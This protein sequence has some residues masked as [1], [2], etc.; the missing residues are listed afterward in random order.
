MN[1]IIP[2]A[3]YYYA[4]AVLIFY[5]CQNGVVANQKEHF[6]SI[7]RYVDRKCNSLVTGQPW[8]FEAKAV[9]RTTHLAEFD[10]FEIEMID[11]NE[12]VHFICLVTHSC[13]VFPS[14]TQCAC[15][16]TNV[17]NY[18]V[19]F[20]IVVNID[21]STPHLLNTL[22][23][24][25]ISTTHNS[26]TS[27]NS[28][29]PYVGCTSNGEDSEGGVG[30]VPAKKGDGTF[31]ITTTNIRYNSTCAILESMHSFWAFTATAVVDAADVNSFGDVPVTIAA[32]GKPLCA[33]DLWCNIIRIDPSNMYLLFSPTLTLPCKCS[34]TIDRK[35][36]FCKF[37]QCYERTFY[38]F[39]FNVELLSLEEHSEHNIVIQVTNNETDKSFN[40]DVGTLKKITPP[41]NVTCTVNGALVILGLEGFYAP[42]VDS[43]GDA[44]IRCCVANLLAP[45]KPYRASC[46][47]ICNR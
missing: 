28:I 31:T 24:V 25:R 33:F 13:E 26:S 42:V 2:K 36:R 45:N 29:T 16:E 44:V 9:I 41:L 10:E 46:C 20:N 1:L 37:K 23:E 18:A 38:K 3:F 39:I 11:K 34:K 19:A 4:V 47:R 12:I 15:N 6:R 35:D 22:A 32:K 17:G 8:V 7:I 43:D 21:A 14:A 27:S 40:K 5:Q 30:T